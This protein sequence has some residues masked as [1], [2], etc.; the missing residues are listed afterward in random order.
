[1][2]KGNPEAEFTAMGFPFIINEI[3]YEWLLD[4]QEPAGAI[5]VFAY[6]LELMPNNASL[7]DSMGEACY[8]SKHWE[9][10]VKHYRKSLELDPSNE[11]AR[12][13][14]AKIQA[15]HSEPKH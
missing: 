4:K 11:N 5:N 2:M 7:H 9:R 3:G 10:S 1:M 12:E 8:E 13:M 14:L 6:G 15:M